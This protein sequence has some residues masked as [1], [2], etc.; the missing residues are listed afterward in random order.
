MKKHS[1]KEEANLDELDYMI[2]QD[3]GLKSDYESIFKSDKKDELLKDLMKVDFSNLNRHKGNS[4][5]LDTLEIHNNSEKDGLLDLTH[6]SKNKS[7]NKNSNENFESS[8]I[9]RRDAIVFGQS[10]NG[11][12]KDFNEVQNKVAHKQ[13][14]QSKSSKRRE[15]FE[16][17]I[18]ESFDNRDQSGSSLLENTENIIDFNNLNYELFNLQSLKSKI[19]KYGVLIKQSNKIEEASDSLRKVFSLWE[20]Y[21]ENLSIAKLRRF[22][23]EY[24]GMNYEYEYETRLAS[25]DEIRNEIYKVTVG[26]LDKNFVPELV[27]EN[28]KLFFYKLNSFNL[29]NNLQDKTNIN[30]LDRL[31]K[32]FINFLDESDLYDI[33][34]KFVE[35]GMERIKFVRDLGF[36][37][38]YSYAKILNLNYK[39]DLEALKEVL[40][41]IKTYILPIFTMDFDYSMEKF[42]KEGENM[43]SDFYIDMDQE[44][45]SEYYKNIFGDLDWELRNLNDVFA[46]INEN[47]IHQVFF[48]QTELAISNLNDKKLIESLFYVSNRA[49]DRQ[50]RGYLETLADLNYINLRIT[51]EFNSEDN[52]LDSLPVSKLFCMNLSLN[53]SMKA[54]SNFVYLS[55]K[56]YSQLLR[57]RTK[58][59]NQVSTTPT[60]ESLH[61]IGTSMELMTLSRLNELFDESNARKYKNWRIRMLLLSVINKSFLIDFEIQFYELLEDVIESPFIDETEYR[62]ILDMLVKRTDELWEYLLKE[63]RLTNYYQDKDFLRENAIKYLVKEPFTGLNMAIAELA[64][65]FIMLEFEEDRAKARYDFEKFCAV[66]GQSLF[67]EELDLAGI[68]NPMDLDNLKSLAFAIVNILENLESEESEQ[69]Q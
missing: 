8:R 4:S 28:G 53:N 49:I 7:N 32:E 41:N 65:V 11:L 33:S 37:D 69:K 55:G 68:D 54:I 42:S 35:L 16:E 45:F 48:P 23:E 1:K 60:A 29:L 14:K 38:Y 24:A 30:N 2:P 51:N 27:K 25:Y 18:K 21:Q 36:K 62:L 6:E 47:R 66:S 12:S 64:S 52:F 59:N 5:D 67:E 3:S 20:N 9:K 22:S 61:F 10:L 63:Y 31:E 40:N 26:L 50:S 17:V 46:Y 13:E 43:L 34:N 39:Q 19:R 58:Y 56:A 15:S 44:E 57:F